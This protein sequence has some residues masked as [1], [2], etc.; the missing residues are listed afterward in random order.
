[1][2]EA[3]L[4]LAMCLSLYIVIAI[5][6]TVYSYRRLHRPGVSAP[7]RAMFVKKHF[8]YVVVFII[9]W[10]IQQ[11]A[12]YFRLFNPEADIDPDANSISMR[13]N[14]PNHPIEALAMLLGM[15]EKKRL[16]GAS[17]DDTLDLNPFLVVSG[18]MTFSTG[19]FLTGVRFFEPLFRHLALKKVYEFWGILYEPSTEGHSEEELRAATDSLNSILAS[20]LNVEL[21]YIIL[22]S[23]TAFS[24]D[25]INDSSSNN[26]DSG[27]II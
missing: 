27:L 22:K 15:R 6:S 16:V 7:V 10:M 24:R 23:I 26:R 11:S 1:M 3:S 2:P 18:V 12:N 14:N 9:I 19:I 8:L 17:G 13:A 21:V 4:V 25:E 5:Y 20:S